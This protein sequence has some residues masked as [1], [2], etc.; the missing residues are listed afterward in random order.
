MFE[1]ATTSVRDRSVTYGFDGPVIETTDVYDG[2]DV[3]HERIKVTCTHSQKNKRYE[4][5][6]SWCKASKRPGGYGVEQFAI[7]TD[8][9]L[10]VC[11]EST[12]R[13]SENKFRAFCVEAQRVCVAIANDEHNVSTVNELLRKAR[14]FAVVAA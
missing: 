6:V 8:P 1:K 9:Y 7:F 4:V 13:F 10:L 2:A 11:A 5:H 14:G 3:W 12:G